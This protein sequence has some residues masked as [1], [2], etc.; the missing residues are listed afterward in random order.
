MT[1][2]NAGK[3]R[4][5]LA[6]EKVAK[7]PKSLVREDRERI[8]LHLLLTNVFQEKFKNTAYSTNSYLTTS[9]GATSVSSGKRTIKMH[10]RRAAKQQVASGSG[11]SSGGSSGDGGGGGNSNSNGGG[12]SSNGGG[13]GS[14]NGGSGGGGGGG[15]R[16][17]GGGGG[18]GSKRSKW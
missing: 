15:K 4:K 17:G 18:S 5:G 7:A 9:D 14:S 16:T 1:C 13:G 11:G 10:F 2:N 8:V 6:L 3:A 12:G